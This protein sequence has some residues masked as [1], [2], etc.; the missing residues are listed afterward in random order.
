[1]TL[2]ILGAHPLAKDEQGRLKSR[3]ATI[4]PYGNTLVTLPGIHATQRQSYLDLL[5]EHRRHA[6]WTKLTLAQRMAEWENGVDLIIEGDAILIRPDPE[7]M[8]AAFKADELLGEIVF[9]RQIRFLNIRNEK[10]R[11]AIKRRG[12]WWRITPVPKTTDEMRQM[13]LASRIAIGGK[14][15]YY[16]NAST[17]TKFLTCEEFARL[18]QLD[19][20]PLRQHL[21]EVAEYCTRNNR[22]GNPEIGFFLTDG[23]FSRADFADYDFATM[24]TAACREAHQS[25]AERF[26]AAVPADLRGDDVEHLLWRNRMFA[27]LI[28][29]RD[30]VVSEASILGVGSEFFMRIEW[31]PGGRIEGGE[32]ILAPSFEHRVP[33]GEARERERQW[34]EL[35]RGFLFNLIRQ[36][37]DLEYVNIGR[38]VESNTPRPTDKGRYDA[39]IAQLKPQDGQHEIVKIIRM[40]KW[41][42][43]EHLDDGKTLLQAMLESE[44]YSEYILDR[45]LA[46]RQL[47]INLPPQITSMK[48]SETYW[49]NRW[50]CR[51]ITIW[52]PY[53]ER[54]YISGISSDKIP[55]FR[56]A[57]RQFA[58][59]LASLLG[60]AA[61]GNMIV[62]RCDLEGTVVFDRGD[63]VVVSD[64]AG[65][66]TD[67]IV[68][69]QMGSFRDYAQGLERF[70]AAYAQ[71]IIRRWEFLA[72]P[73]EFASAYLAAFLD[74]FTRLQQEYRKRKRTY[75]SL[76]SHRRWDQRGSLRYRWEQVLKRLNETNPRELT[77]Q[78]RTHVPPT[79]VQPGMPS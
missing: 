34:D 73:D 54:D 17:G 67:I 59:R 56:L 24:P 23:E 22:L 79:P 78:I 55:G 47:G 2:Q 71:P 31:L 35:S 76:F 30:E 61:A 25:L 77:E 12:E 62:G 13:I 14:E 40:Q 32:L 21:V 68:A 15:I 50:D 5:E 41:G 64:A 65:L 1:M 38:I 33:P 66:P 11:S 6:G 7:N 42:V 4:F 29:Q 63:E 43:R 45:R 74:R 75:D 58:L 44:D 36:Y 48:I 26:Q 19:D 60:R 46:C 72:A 39:F 70:A 57:D 51:G 8:V 27:A 20:E 16:Y 18:G 53:F 28:S 69:D 52:S 49:G 9:P 3:I 37:G 10:V